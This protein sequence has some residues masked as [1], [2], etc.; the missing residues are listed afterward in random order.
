MPHPRMPRPRLLVRDPSRPRTRPR[1]THPH[2]QRCAPVLVAP[3]L[4]RP[5]GVG[6]PHECRGPADPR[7]RVVGPHPTVAH[8]PSLRAVSTR[9]PYLAAH[10]T[11]HTT[12]H[13]CTP[14]GTR[15]QR[16]RRRRR[17]IPSRRRGVPESL[18]L[19]RCAPS[20]NEREGSGR[21]ASDARRNV[22]PPPSVV[23]RAN[24]DE[25]KRVSPAGAS[26]RP[27]EYAFR[28]GRCAPSL[29][30]RCV[31][32]CV[33]SGRCAPSFNDRCA[34]SCVSPRSTTGVQDRAFRLAQRPGEGAC[35]G[36]LRRATGPRARCVSSP[37]A[38][39]AA[40][41]LCAHPRNRRAELPRVRRRNVRRTGAGARRPR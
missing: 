2:R 1:R 31:G 12:A 25:T 19:G 18:R 41:R 35:F 33:S 34:G 8:T 40:G 23:E 5:L 15:T 24:R 6:D 30:D 38:R 11:V 27:A 20:L 37:C 22:C 21:C 29:N 39:S 14:P 36:L 4:A 13:N 32:S 3:P 17:R 26:R 16:R 10:L 9:P 7:T 28:L